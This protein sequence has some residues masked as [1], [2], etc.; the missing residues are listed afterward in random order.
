MDTKNDTLIANRSNKLHFPCLTLA[1]CIRIYKPN[2]VSFQA[3]CPGRTG[4]TPGPLYLEA[5]F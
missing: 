5:H 1:S 3:P 4:T 2:H